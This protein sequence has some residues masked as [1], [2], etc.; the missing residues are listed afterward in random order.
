VRIKDHKYDFRA[1]RARRYR[2]LL[3]FVCRWLGH[4]PATVTCIELQPFEATVWSV[5]RDG[6]P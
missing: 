1:D 6:A 4:D 5:D 2:W 3:R